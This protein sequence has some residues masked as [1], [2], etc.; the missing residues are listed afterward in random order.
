[1]GINIL[2]IFLIMNEIFI[3]VLGFVIAKTNSLSLKQNDELK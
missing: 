1:M 2:Y 3:F